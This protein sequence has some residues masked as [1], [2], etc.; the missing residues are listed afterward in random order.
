MSNFELIDDYLMNRLTE[1]ERIDF[2]NAIKTDTALK[3]EVEHQ[4]FIIEEIQK[5]RAK[6]IKEM[7]NKVPVSGSAYFTAYK[8]AATIIVASIIGAGIYLYFTDRTSEDRTIDSSIEDTMLGN[9][10]EESIKSL[11]DPL[12]FE[13]SQSQ[14]D[15]SSDVASAEAMNSGNENKIPSDAEVS[16]PAINIIE[17]TPNKKNAETLQPNKTNPISKVEVS[18]E[19]NTLYNFHYNFSKGKLTLYGKFTNGNYEIID[20]NPTHHTLYLYF[21]GNFYFLDDAKRGITPLQK[22][23]DSSVIKKLQG[24]KN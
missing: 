22:T 4:K 10:S 13:M 6:E 14:D 3:T 8:I 17:A 18:I 15:E 2:E 5:T 7:L 16:K 20:I 1:K 11:D 23:T 19:H 24:L 9:S 12:K 21:D